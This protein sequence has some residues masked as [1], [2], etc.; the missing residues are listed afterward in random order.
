M[1]RCYQSL[2]YRGLR[3]HDYV[4]MGTVLPLLMLLSAIA[5]GVTCWRT[6]RSCP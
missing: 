3:W 6:R 2:G 5:I 4:V 1:S